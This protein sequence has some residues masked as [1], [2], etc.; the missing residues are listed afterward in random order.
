M[1]CVPSTSRYVTPVNPFYTRVPV[2]HWKSSD[3]RCSHRIC[4]SLTSLSSL[5]LSLTAIFFFFGIRNL[6]LVVTPTDKDDAK[7]QKQWPIPSSIYVCIIIYR[8][9]RLGLDGG[10]W[11]VIGICD[12][13][14]TCFNYCVC[15][16]GGWFLL[17]AF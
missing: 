10:D 1:L 13:V 4:P 11:I 12:G 15:P 5:Q 8:S 3:F 2:G 16:Y 7:M 9:R 6:L 14:G 17:Q